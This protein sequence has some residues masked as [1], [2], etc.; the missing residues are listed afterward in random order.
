MSALSAERNTVKVGALPLTTYQDVPVKAGAVIYKGGLVALSGGY[1]VSA[2]AASGLTIIGRAEQTVD[3]TTGSNG[4]LT[5]QVARGQFRYDIYGSDAVTA[6]DLGRDVFAYDDHTIAKTDGGSGARSR[7]G[8]LVGFSDD[9]TEAIVEITSAPDGAGAVMVHVLPID[10]ASI[11]AGVAVGP[12]VMPFSGRIVK[13][14]YL[15]AKAAS[16]GG[17]G[18]TLQPRITPS[19]GSAAATTGGLITL[20]T[21]T[22]AIGAPVAGTAIT[23][24]NTFKAGDSID[25]LGA[26]N[27]AAFVEGF[28]SVRLHIAP[29]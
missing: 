5:V 6:A 21:A 18:V 22:S 28:G 24:A 3:N 26:L 29:A 1:A 2:S 7:A 13:A 27:V 16:T 11:P 14:E 19:G 10:L 8:K 15:A 9:G 4:T 20:T 17:K 23:A 25:L 12:V